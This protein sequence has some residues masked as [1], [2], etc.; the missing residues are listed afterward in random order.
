MS[1]FTEVK[2]WMAQAGQN[3]PNLP[4]HMVSEHDFLLRKRLIDEE[5]VELYD[6]MDAFDMIE[7]A[8]GIADLLVVTYGTAVAYGMNADAIFTEVMR[9]NWTKLGPQGFIRDKGGKVI[10]P[11]TYKQPD[12]ARVLREGQ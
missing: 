9:S 6:A 8:D 5:T 4:T 10:K 3:A 12:I 1:N 11:E 2:L 7:I